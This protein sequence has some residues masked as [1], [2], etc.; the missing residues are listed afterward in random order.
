M[1]LN[2]RSPKRGPLAVVVAGLAL[3][4]SPSMFASGSYAGG[5]P[6]VPKPKHENEQF[7]AGQSIY[8]GKA[9]LAATDKELAST[10]LPKLQALERT[11]ESR[12]G[13]KKDLSSMAGR[14]TEKQLE[15]LVSFINTR[16]KGE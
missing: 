12:A 16:Y 4:T 7:Q 8:N 2:F 5:P 15:S 14:L 13:I 9:H 6:T 1:P 10:Q 11:L 3:L